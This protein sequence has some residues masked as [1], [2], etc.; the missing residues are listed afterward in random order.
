M[1]DGRIYVMG[2]TTDGFP[3][4]T[5][6][7]DG[8][9]EW[10]QPVAVGNASTFP[11]DVTL[12]DRTIRNANQCSFDVRFN[13]KAKREAR[14]FCTRFGDNGDLFLEGSAVDG[15]LTPNPQNPFFAEGGP[16]DGWTTKGT[17]GVQFDPIVKAFHGD[18]PE[19][20]PAEWQVIWRSTQENPNGNTISVHQGSPSYVSG[21]GVLLQF[22]L[23]V[24]QVPCSTKALGNYWGDYTDLGT[25]AIPLADTWITPFTQNFSGCDFE[26]PFTADMHVGAVSF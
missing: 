14:V 10:V 26:G 12:S 24:E 20:P 7:K 11:L 15:D 2:M 17:P 3:I 18:D 16:V 19:G 13:E 1:F 25:M 9:T 8:G 22:Q 4:M 21:F 6:M 5:Y 23:I